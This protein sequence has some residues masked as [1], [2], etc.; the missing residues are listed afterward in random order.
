MTEEEKKQY[1]EWQTATGKKPKFS[2]IDTAKIENAGILLNDRDLMDE[3][4][5][6]K[7]A[8]DF[9]LILAE[10]CGNAQIT[11]I[12]AT[13]YNS[14]AVRLFESIKGVIDNGFLLFQDKQLKGEELTRKRVEMYAQ[15]DREEPPHSQQEIISFVLENGLNVPMDEIKRFWRKNSKNHFKQIDNWRGYLTSMSK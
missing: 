11:E 13:G 12:T 1:N 15:N 7:V 10:Y 9:V 2:Q 4:K 14:T 3:I 6:Q 5:A 8:L